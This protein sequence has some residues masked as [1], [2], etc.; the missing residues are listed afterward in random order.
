MLWLVTFQWILW[1]IGEMNGVNNQ[2]IS[3]SQTHKLINATSSC[4]CLISDRRCF[5]ISNLMALCLSSL[6]PTNQPHCFEQ[7]SV[8]TRSARGRDR[9]FSNCNNHL[10][11][12]HHKADI[13]T[14][15]QT[16]S[17]KFSREVKKWL[18]SI[19]PVTAVPRYGALSTWSCSWRK[20]M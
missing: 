2:Q 18:T 17:L 7:A 16:T 3:L 12:S 13:L 4:R 8:S 5:L 11:R 20:L 9:A 10:P 14:W 6:V 19:F 15:I 1:S